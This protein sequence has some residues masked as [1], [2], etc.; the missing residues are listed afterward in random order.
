MQARRPRFDTDPGVARVVT[1][2]ILAAVGR[3]ATADPAVRMEP[4][5]VNG[6]PGVVAWTGDAVVLVASLVLVDGRVGQVLIVRNPEKLGRSTAPRYQR[7]SGDL[8]SR[9]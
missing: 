2:R 8:G 5:E 6:M 7:T 9:A 1:E 4:A 3:E